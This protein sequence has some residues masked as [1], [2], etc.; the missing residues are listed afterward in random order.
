M[1]SNP[2]PLNQICP[3]S[4]R[5]RLPQ[6]EQ[7]RTPVLP[8]Q[9]V[10]GGEWPGDYAKKCHLTRKEHQVWEVSLPMPPASGESHLLFNC[11]HICSVSSLPCRHISCGNKEML[12][13]LTC[14]SENQC[15]YSVVLKA[16]S[17]SDSFSLFYCSGI[18]YSLD[19]IQ[20]SAV[21]I[22]M[23]ATTGR[24]SYLL[25]LPR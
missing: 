1:L 17:F 22:H 14:N 6:E 7:R 4:H 23:I 16:L 2:E 5:P 20:I 25:I 13:T 9:E 21:L 3:P 10:R 18:L 19:D 11:C 24:I 8:K 12:L 15:Y